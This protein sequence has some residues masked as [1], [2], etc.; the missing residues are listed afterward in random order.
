MDQGLLTGAVF[1]DLLKAFDSVDHDIIVSKLKAAG[2]SGTELHWF[3]DYLSNRT[4][5]VNVENELSGATLIT[6]RVPNF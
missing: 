2:I 6:S 4:Q 3:K 5:Q 1:I